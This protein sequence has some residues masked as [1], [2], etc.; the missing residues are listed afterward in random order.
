MPRKQSTVSPSHQA[1]RSGT[2]AAIHTV[3][4]TACGHD[5]PEQR[6][7][8]LVKEWEQEFWPY[9]QRERQLLLNA[10]EKTL[11]DL[12]GEPAARAEA[13]RAIAAELK[14][15][16]TDP[17][18]PLGEAHVSYLLEEKVDEAD[19]LL[20]TRA[21][22]KDDPFDVVKGID[23]IGVRLSDGQIF[24]IEV[25]ASRKTETF[26]IKQTLVDLRNDLQ[27]A[28]ILAKAQLTIGSA[29]YE[30]IQ[31][32]YLRALRRTTRQVE[33]LVSPKNPAN[34]GFSRLGAVVSGGG[35]WE[36]LAGRACPCDVSEQNPC[37]LLL[38]H[39]EDFG[40]QLELLALADREATRLLV[41]PM[42]GAR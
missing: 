9:Y 19:R 36:P 40:Q 14:T 34:H 1:S 16:G 2:N 15:L 28:R 10:A 42:R 41:L 25:K 18:G 38:L 11:S 21:G 24:Y 8:L 35:K 39:V 23:L 22:W 29:A 17:I 37:A 30:Y 20:L 6:V 31:T 3:P 27:L 5:L 32:A 4:A 13:Q 12:V 26:L 7:D 33:R